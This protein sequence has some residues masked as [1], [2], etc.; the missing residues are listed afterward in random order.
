ML[1]GFVP[2]MHQGCTH[3]R[4]QVNVAP[5][6]HMVLPNINGSLVWKLLFVTPLLCI[7]FLGGCHSFV[8][9]MHP[10]CGHG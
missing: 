8:K 3:P 2:S 1:P 9:F 10:W 6:F 5:V 4:C 7:E